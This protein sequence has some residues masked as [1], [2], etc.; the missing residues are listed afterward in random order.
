MKVFELIKTVLD[1][2]YVRI[3]GDEADKDKRIKEALESLRETYL[4]SAETGVSNDYADLVTR[5]AYIYKYVTSHANVV[6]QLVTYC[7]ELASLFD[8]KQVAI[9]CVGGGPGSDFLGLLKFII[10]NGQKPH[11]RLNLFDKEATWNE[12]WQDV[13]EKLSSQL[14]ISNSFSQF[15]VTDPETWKNYNKF[16]MSDLFTMVYFMS[17]I[18]ALRDKAEPFFSNLFGNAKQSS[19]MLFVDNNNKDFPY[20]WF[21]E[22]VAKHNWKVIKSGK[23]E[24]KMDDWSEEKSDLGDYYKKFGSPKLT[25]NVAWRICQKQ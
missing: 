23:G 14:L 8:K 18:N 19:L 25:A 10:K 24:L 21:D 4:N 20:G 1:E 13:D 6:Y 9:T 2:I 3:D 17:E 15:D 22:L 11:L 7:P 5:F 12:C 16:L